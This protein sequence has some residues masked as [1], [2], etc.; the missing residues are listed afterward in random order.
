MV[1]MLEGG[2]VLAAAAAA[3]GVKGRPLGQATGWVEGRAE[4]RKRRRRE[5]RR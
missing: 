2:S 4:G 3:C 1:R 5:R